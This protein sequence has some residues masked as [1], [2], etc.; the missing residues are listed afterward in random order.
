MGPNFQQNRLKRGGELGNTTLFII[1]ASGRLFGVPPGS[2]FLDF[3]PNLGGFS[4]HFWQFFETVFQQCCYISSHKLAI[5]FPMSLAAGCC[6]AGWL[7]AGGESRS[8]KNLIKDL[9]F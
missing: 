8:E 3:R 2:D 1:F 4:D 5:F 9:A 7:E 6:L